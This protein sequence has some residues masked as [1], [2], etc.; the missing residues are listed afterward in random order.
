LLPE[1][2]EFGYLPFGNHISSLEELITRF[3]GGSPERE[4]ETQELCELMQWARNAGIQRLIVNGSYV[5]AKVAPNDV[6]IVALP[7]VI[8]RGMRCLGV[9]L[10]LDGLSCRYS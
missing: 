2:N 6:D 9:S 4:V 10:K 1:F 5:T 7:G 8:I 3:G